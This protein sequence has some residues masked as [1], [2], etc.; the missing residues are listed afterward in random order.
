M[1]YLGGQVEPEIAVVGQA[2]L[3]KERHFVAEAELH[4]TT[5][6]SG[7]AEVD[8]VL[9]REGKS[10]GLSQADLDVLCL[11]LNVGVLAESD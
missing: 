8:K 5:E 11:I 10:N 7:F 6:A 3:D 9:Q 1:A 4:L 2:V